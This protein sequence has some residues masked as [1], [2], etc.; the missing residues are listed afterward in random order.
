MK[1]ALIG[2]T[3][4]VGSNLKAAGGFT[5]LFNSA[6][7]ADIEG[8]TFDEIVCAG[9]AGVK[10]LA[11]K[12]P[13]RD[14]QGIRVLLDALGTVK[15]RRFV[16]ISTI[17][18]YPD[19][20]RSDDEGADLSPDAGQAYG[21]HRLRVERFVLDRFPGAL[22]ARLPALF[23]PGLKKNVLFDLL[24][25]NQTDRINPA[26][27]FQWYPVERLAGDLATAASAG[28]GLVNLFPEP[29][30][31]ASIIDGMFP[32]ARVGLPA[33]P[34]PR[35]GLR[36]RHAD[37]FGGRN[38]F[39]MSAGAVLADMARFVEAERAAQASGGAAA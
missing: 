38:G 29:V 12:E 23:G 24:H 19:P 34:A 25:D 4:F 16:L 8:E 22:V 27:V 32:G 17:D 37:L 26:A 11:N 20:S 18:V 13:E 10:W 31:S 39:V 36:S 14:W 33:E 3:G 15:T 35:Y 9:V 28:L 2:H 1:R 7:I 5:H 21:R 30:A 6:N